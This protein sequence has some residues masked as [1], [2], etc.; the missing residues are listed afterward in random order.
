MLMTVRQNI[1]MNLAVSNSFQT[2]DF[3][4]MTFPNEFSIGASLSRSF[5]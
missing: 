4:A 3:D 5:R 2:V 1:I